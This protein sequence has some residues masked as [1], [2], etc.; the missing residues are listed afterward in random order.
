MFPGNP[1]LLYLS[2]RESYCD[3]SSRNYYGPLETS[4]LW[5]ISRTYFSKFDRLI[6]LCNCPP[7]RSFWTE[8][9]ACSKNIFPTTNYIS[10]Y[11]FSS[12][13]HPRSIYQPKSQI[14]RHECFTGASIVEIYW[15]G[16]LHF[17]RAVQR[18]VSSL[19]ATSSSSLTWLACVFRRIKRPRRIYQRSFSRTLMIVKESWR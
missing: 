11:P 5:R 9:H 4:S 7:I 12:L 18:H 2:K 8:S 6:I 10:V 3:F 19:D 15:R 17:D 13:Q 14:V 1:L 16:G